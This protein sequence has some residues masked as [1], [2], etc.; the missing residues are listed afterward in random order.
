MAKQHKQPNVV[1]ELGRP[2]T[3]T[4]TAARKAKDSRLYRERKTVNNLVFSLLVSV[5]LV[6]VI[7]LMVPRGT[8]DFDK[9]S[10]DVAELARQASQGTAQVLAVPEVPEGWLAKRAVL[11]QEAE[12]SY[13]QIHYTTADGAYASV[14]Q[15]FSEDGTPVTD[16]VTGNQWLVGQ[17]ETLEPTGSE[18]L[19]GVS[20]TVYDYPDRSIDSSNIRF[21]LTG[22]LETAHGT[23][24]LIV[25]GTDVAGTIRVLATQVVD[26][27][28]A[29]ETS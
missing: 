20:W 17:T 18:E 5:G 3:A 21:A 25:S 10:V 14:V 22:N 7:F 4:E 28:T 1:A 12:F 13:W 6:F 16:L 26:S 23:D 9:Q 19:A 8:G 29:E 15:A 11:R 27:L 24:T 2:E